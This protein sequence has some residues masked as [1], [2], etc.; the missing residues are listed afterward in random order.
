MVEKPQTF[1]PVDIE[2]EIPVPPEFITPLRDIAAQAGTRV[3]FDGCVGGRPEP[4]IKWFRQAARYS[5]V[6]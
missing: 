4:S 5:G 1:Q 3:T 6:Y 2:I